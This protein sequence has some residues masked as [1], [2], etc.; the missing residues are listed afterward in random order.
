M[1][2][3][4]LGHRIANGLGELGPL[5]SRLEPDLDIQGERGELVPRGRGQGGEQLALQSGAHLHEIGGPETVTFVDP[6]GPH[7]PENLGQEHIGLRARAVSLLDEV[8]LA[9]FTRGLQKA[10]VCESPHVIVHLLRG[11]AHPAGD[12]RRRAGPPGF[13]QDPLTE[14]V[15]EKLSPVRLRHGFHR[16]KAVRVVHALCF[17]VKIYLSTWRL[18]PLRIG[19]LTPTTDP[20]P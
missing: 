3:D 8:A 13:R 9:A 17:Y 20:T 2:P 18:E 4:D 16:G 11:Q 1:L 5:I 7:V 12:L 6:P 10:R 15:E 14:W 19:D